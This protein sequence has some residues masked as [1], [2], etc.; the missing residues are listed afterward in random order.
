[1]ASYPSDERGLPIVRQHRLSDSGAG[2]NAP[3][4]GFGGS[5]LNHGCSNRVCR[6][7]YGEIAEIVACTKG[8]YSQQ[9]KGRGGSHLLNMIWRITGE[10]IEDLLLRKRSCI[11]YN[12]F[13]VSIKVQ[14]ITFYDRVRTFY[15]PQF[16][17]LPDFTQKFHL[18]NVLV[19]PDAHYHQTV[20]AYICHEAIAAM[21][22]TDRF[23]A[24]AALKDSVRE[25]G[26]YL[27]RNPD[28]TLTIDIGVANLEFRGREYRIKWCGEFLEA[29]QAYVGPEAVVSPYDPPSLTKGGPFAPCRF[30]RGCETVPMLQQ[31][32]EACVDAESRISVAEMYDGKGG[33]GYRKTYW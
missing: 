6:G 23:V 24:E 16:V 8:L 27:N 14:K 29:L 26:K 17:L 21:A 13:H 9:T 5:A 22:G 19:M 25:I 28:E 20:P 30:D 10:M 2:G 12:F 1:M 4:R 31:E 3:R 15:K 33:S 11:F 18:R 32:V 7:C